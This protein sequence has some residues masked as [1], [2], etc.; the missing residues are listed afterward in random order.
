MF[1]ARSCFLYFSD[2]AEPAG[3]RSWFSSG[4]CDALFGDSILQEDVQ[5]EEDYLANYFEHP[6]DQCKRGGDFLLSGSGFKEN[7]KCA[8]FSNV[9]SDDDGGAKETNGCAHNHLHDDQA[10]QLEAAEMP[11]SLEN[12]LL[13]AKCE[14]LQSRRQRF[15]LIHPKDIVEG[16][17]SST[18]EV[19][20][21]PA[22]KEE[23]PRKKE[24]CDLKNVLSSCKRENDQKM[25]TRPLTGAFFS[26][27]NRENNFAME[28]INSVAEKRNCAA[29]AASNSRTEENKGY[30]STSRQEGYSTLSTAR[31]AAS[32]RPFSETSNFV[33][34]QNLDGKVGKWQCPRKR[35]ADFGPPM[36][37]LRL[38]RWVR[39][40]ET[41]RF[42]HIR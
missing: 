34:L 27:K 32:R 17:T 39:R 22:I 28:I 24:G 26:P 37:Q 13:R 29:S 19:Y 6:N 25:V 16:G 23:N 9:D 12:V 10:T 42:Q 36:K 33:Q 1:L 20:T 38:E 40:S 41:K 3:I 30:D 11:F 2:R 21:V 18:E 5:G 31:M 7:N 35:K 15:S 8:V 14:D 4:E